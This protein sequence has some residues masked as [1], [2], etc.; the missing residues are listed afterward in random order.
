MD[1]RMAMWVHGVSVF[2]E[3]TSGDAGA[4][5]P[6]IQ[7]Q[8][9]PWSDIVGLRQG[10]G[11]TFRGK[12]NHDNWFHFSIPTPVLVPVFHSEPG[13]G[14]D[15][16]YGQRV[17]LERV[18]VLFQNEVTQVHGLSGAKAWIT[19]VHVWDG[20]QN[21]YDTSSGLIDPGIVL[22]PDD[23]EEVLLTDDFAGQHHLSIQDGWNVWYLVQNR[24]RIT[25][26]INWGICISVNVH[27]S[28]ESNITFVAAGADFLLDV[29]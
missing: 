11:A 16:P 4:D 28:Q 27:F 13:R 3:R 5:G 14:Y 24:G 25:P 10:F 19:Q 26:S 21:R 6:L 17:R 15:K 22:R 29:P 18:F 12:Q 1:T 23:G 20:A 8:H 2:P 9:I 7:S